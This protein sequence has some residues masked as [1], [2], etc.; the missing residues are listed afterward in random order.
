[1]TAYIVRRLAW[2]LVLLVLVSLVTF[3]VF[4]LFPSTDPAVLR[5]GRSPSPEQVEAIRHNLGLD[6]SKP[7]QFF[8]YMKGVVLHFDFGRSYQN[9]AQVRELIFERLPA[10]IY[11]TIGAVIVWLSI[12]IPVG[13]ISSIKRRTIFDRVAMSG[14]LLGISAPVYWVGLVSLYL[15]S[16]DIGQ[17]HIFLGAGQYRPPSEGFFHFFGSLILPWL[18][19]ALAFAAFYARL[20]RSN[21]LEVMSED[22]IRTARAKGLR[23]RRVVLRHGM[24]SAIT[25]VVTVLGLDIGVLLGGAILTE[26]VFNIPGIGRL[27]YGAITSGDLTIVQ[28][29]VLLGAFFI[30]FLNLIVDVLYAFLDPRIRYS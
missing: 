22:Y 16:K 24:R 26:T 4:Y 18:V 23:E 8:Q 2:I 14:A 3:V 9:N 13:L 7:E 19:L 27:A 17:F 12:A 5:A 20:L 1:M 15:F 29:T 10:T 28:G 11:L 25:P 21:M 6:K 30:I